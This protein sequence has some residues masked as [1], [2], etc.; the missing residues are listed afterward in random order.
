MTEENAMDE[1]EQVQTADP[2]LDGADTVADLGDAAK[3]QDDADFTETN[4]NV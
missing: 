3:G 2:A 4:P 1:L